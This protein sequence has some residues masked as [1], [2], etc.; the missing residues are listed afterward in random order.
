MCLQGTQESWCAQ[1]RTPARSFTQ[2]PTCRKPGASRWSSAGS[3]T[4]VSHRRGEGLRR[5]A[6]QRLHT[7]GSVPF[8]HKRSFSHWRAGSC[9]QVAGK[10]RRHARCTIC[11]AHNCDVEVACG[12]FAKKRQRHCPRRRVAVSAFGRRD[13]LET[14]VSSRHTIYK[15]C[16]RE[17]CRREGAACQACGRPSSTA[18]L[19]EAAALLHVVEHTQTPQAHQIWLKML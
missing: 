13:A 1:R 18:C 9:L 14:S 15:R 8:L 5:M 17:L 7:S 11:L 4:T 19:R 6:A 16:M 2:L 10:R 12:A 3:S